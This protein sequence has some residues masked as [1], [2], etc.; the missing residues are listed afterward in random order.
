MMYACSMDKSSLKFWLLFELKT[1]AF[2]SYSDLADR[3]LG[4]GPAAKRLS[5]ADLAEW[6]PPSREFVSSFS[7]WLFGNSCCLL[8]VFSTRTY[9]TATDMPV[10]LGPAPW[11]VAVRE[12][13]LGEAS[14]QR[15]PERLSAQGPLKVRWRYHSTSAACAL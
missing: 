12:N 13:G 15:V 9:L 4:L 6:Q 14:A 1:S 10:R 11:P 5:R 3:K 2:V 7:P 8:F